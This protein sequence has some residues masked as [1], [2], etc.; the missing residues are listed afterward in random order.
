MFWISV[1][2]VDQYQQRWELIVMDSWGEQ[3]LLVYLRIQYWLFVSYKNE[4]PDTHSIVYEVQPHSP[5]ILVLKL[6]L[7]TQAQWFI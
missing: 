7:I 6:Y 4:E 5:G 3:V 1:Y 2:R